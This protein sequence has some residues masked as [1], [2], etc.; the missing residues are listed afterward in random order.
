MTKECLGSQLLRSITS[1]V[2]EHKLQQEIFNQE[3]VF[4]I[5]SI[6]EDNGEIWD[7]K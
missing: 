7:K 3:E 4:P 6:R 1:L 5:I 2:M